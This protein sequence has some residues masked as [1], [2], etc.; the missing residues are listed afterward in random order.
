MKAGQRRRRRRACPSIPCILK[1]TL[2]LVKGESTVRQVEDPA[3]LLAVVKSPN[4][5]KIW[6]D[7][8]E[9]GYVVERY[10]INEYL[11][12]T[13]IKGTGWVVS[14]RDFVGVLSVR[15]EEDGTIY[16]WQVSVEDE[17][18]QH[19]HGYVRGELRCSGWVFKPNSDNSISI[20]YILDFDLSCSVPSFVVAHASTEIPLCVAHVRQFILL[21]GH[22]P[23]IQQLAGMLLREQFDTGTNVYT[24]TYIPAGEG[25]TEVKVDDDRMY[26]EGFEVIVKNGK[27]VEKVIGKFVV[28]AENTDEE[29]VVTVK[30]KDPPC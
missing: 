17:L 4:C 28:V 9:G 11:F 2:Y 5:R 23:F 7:K 29:V 18:V 16:F 19:T 12:H 15:K 21:R 8:F 25:T 3:D 14:P 27:V 24:I 6:D 20:T 22:P 10:G 1:G 26:D 13:S 30:G